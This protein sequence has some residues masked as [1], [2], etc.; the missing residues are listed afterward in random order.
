MMAGRALYLGVFAIVMSALVLCLIETPLVIYL[1]LQLDLFRVGA[2]T[3]QSGN[4]QQHRGD[5]RGK[6]DASLSRVVRV[7]S[8]FAKFFRIHLFSVRANF[9]DFVFISGPILFLIPGVSA[10]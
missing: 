4:S 2:M 10:V 8:L 6:A 1:G 3:E 7:F 5:G 9:Y